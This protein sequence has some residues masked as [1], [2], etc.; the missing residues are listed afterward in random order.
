MHGLLQQHH[1]TLLYVKGSSF[2]VGHVVG[3]CSGSGF[4]AQFEKDNLQHTQAHTREE[5][6]RGPGLF[7]CSLQF[8]VCNAVD[9]YPCIAMCYVYI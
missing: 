6:E 5:G 7:I 3:C 4:S 8:A 2:I 1:F 9:P